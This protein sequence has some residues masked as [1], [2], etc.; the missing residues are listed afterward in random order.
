MQTFIKYCASFR[1]EITAPL[2]EAVKTMF[3]EHIDELVLLSL[4]DDNNPDRVLDS[5][6]LTL[7]GEKELVGMSSSRPPRALCSVGRWS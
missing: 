4:T 5:G 6:E 2:V 7:E 3:L 1:K